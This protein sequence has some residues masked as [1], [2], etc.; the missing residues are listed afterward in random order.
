MK[1]RNLVLVVMLMVIGFAA[2]QV[3]I[4]KMMESNKSNSPV[5]EHVELTD[6]DFEVAPLMLVIQA[7]MEKLYFA[8]E[9]N[10]QALVQ[11]LSHEMEEG[12]EE[13]VDAQKKQDGVDVSYHAKIYGLVGVK[14]FMEKYL[15]N[16]DNW[17]DH[18]TRLINDCNGCHLSTKRA[19]IKI[20]EPQVNRF[21]NQ[22][23]QN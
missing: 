17:R 5:Q 2:Q 21:S 12:F 18:Y 3:Q 4:Q 23:F 10:N 11:Y 15:A 14:E 6:S 9:A 1:K 13:L 19:F 20:Q 8:C 7:H 22:N 16:S